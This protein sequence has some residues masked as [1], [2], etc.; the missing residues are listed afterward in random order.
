MRIVCPTCT[1]AYEVPPTLLR[2]GQVVRCARCTGEW[3]PQIDTIAP[4]PGQAR[5]TE[6]GPPRAP[7]P[8]VRPRPVPVRPAPVPAR[9]TAAVR[10]AWCASLVILAALLWGAYSQRDFV[11]QAWPPSV[12][13]YAALGLARH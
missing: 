3:A 4:P 7:S 12:R 10:I 13:L 9:G 8:P 6:L 5:D 2:P 11:M 1:A